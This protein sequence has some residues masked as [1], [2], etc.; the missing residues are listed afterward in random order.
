MK[1]T[2]SG[3]KDIKTGL[4]GDV[5]GLSVYSSSLNSSGPDGAGGITVYYNYA[6]GD[7]A[8]GIAE[9]RGKRMQI[10]RK[11]GGNPSNTYDLADQIGG[12][13]AFNTVFCAKNLSE[14]T[15]SST[16]RIIRQGAAS[17]L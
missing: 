17:A 13:V 16:V 4:V 14:G 9:L 2:E 15:T 3:I 11:K 6:F 1:Y 7:Q 8:L 5:F 10:I 12:A